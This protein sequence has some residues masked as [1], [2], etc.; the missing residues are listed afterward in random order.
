VPTSPK[1]LNSSEIHAA[2]DRLAQAISER[3]PADEKLLLLGIANGGITLAQRLAKK[4]PA[5]R[6]GTL[7]ISFHRDDISR[8]PIPKE[9]V[10]THIPVEVRGAT[11]ILVDDVLF[12]GRTVKA[13]LDELFDHGRPSKVEL[14]VLVDR[15]HHRLPLAA[16]YTGITLTTLPTQKVVVTL[17]AASPKR[18]TIRLEAARAD[19]A[20]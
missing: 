10:P 3:H 16:D 1:S 14:A 6:I 17:D 2:I 12:S 11:V 19:T 9:F 5:A 20:S 8:N 15:G 7:D 4:L 18:D 13:A